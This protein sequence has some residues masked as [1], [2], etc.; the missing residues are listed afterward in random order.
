MT[1]NIPAATA[2][3]ITAAE[4]VAADLLA[5]WARHPELRTSIYIA[6]PMTGLPEFNYPAFNAAAQVLRAAGIP[7]ANPADHIEPCPEPAWNDWM[8]EALHALAGCRAVLLLPGW[9]DSRGARIERWLAAD[10]G[11][12]VYGALGQQPALPHHIQRA[13]D[14]LRREAEGIAEDEGRTGIWTNPEAQ[15]EHEQLL[16]DA[17]MIERAAQRHEAELVEIIG[18]RD[19]AEAWADKLANAI[20]KQFAADIGE[21]SNANNPWAEALAIIEAAEP[22]QEAA[23]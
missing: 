5:H 17:S 6:G 8:R 21:H 10:L 12:P 13:A 7:V 3:S 18:Q 2:K 23:S 9:Q 20:A 19:L 22:V 16:H 4:K 14:L 15:H 1:N 11:M